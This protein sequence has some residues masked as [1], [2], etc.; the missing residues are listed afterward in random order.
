MPGYE[1]VIGL[2]VH[3]QL[4]T[5]TKIFC[6]CPTGFGAPPNTQTCPLCLGLPGSLPVLNRRAVELAVVAALALDC[7]V[8]TRSVFARKNYFYP[9]LPKGYQISQ[10][11]EPLAVGGH[12]EIELDGTPRSIGLARLHLEEDAGKSIHDGMPD[13]DRFSYVDL[14]RAGVGLAEIVTRPE[15]H[16]PLAAYR[17][18]ERLRSTLRCTGVC[19]GNLEEGSLRCDANVSIRAAGRS[20]LGPR[21]ELKNLNSFR[22][23]QRALEFEIARQIRIAEEGG[24]VA[25]QTVL[26]DPAAGVTRPMRGKE[27]ARDYRYFPEPDLPPLVLDPAWIRGLRDGLPELPAARKRRLATS[28]GLGE[29]E[30]HRLSLEAPVADYFEAVA[31]ASGNARAAASFVLNDL[32]RAQREAQRDESDIGLA[33]DLLAELIRLVDRG[34]V[35]HSVA[36][37][38]LFPEVYRSGVSP[39]RLVEERGLAQVSDDAALLDLV[40]QVL[41]DHPGQLA[42]YRAGKTGLLGFFVGQVVRRS[43]GRANP[44]LARELL[45]KEIG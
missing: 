34:T 8:R 14:N 21:T 33:P 43:G 2:E 9:D 13:S 17:F 10:Y 29:I 11:E 44:R 20:E 38:E 24:R 25:Q 28:F 1:A 5:R 41:A 26:W 19:D 35:S 23:V 4:K 12:V 45:Q 15:L 22:N 18:L 31:R 40:R 27:E 3:A 7:E 30:A 6:G 16:T 37:Q 36:R 32:V 42:Q 39:R